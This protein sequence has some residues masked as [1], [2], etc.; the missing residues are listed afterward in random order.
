M[1]KINIG[2]GPRWA[3]PG[4]KTLDF[5]NQQA[6]LLCDLRTNPRLPLA[7]AST[8]K[9]YCSH[10][11][12]HLTDS[13]VLNLFRESR[14]ILKH[15][16]IARF[17]CPDLEK[18]IAQ[19]K[20]GRCDPNAEIIT[21]TLRSAPSHLRLLNVVASFKSPEYRG[22]V[23]TRSG[24]YSGGPFAEE[25]EV[26]KRLRSQDLQSFAD[27][28]QSLVPEDAFY[29]AHINAFWAEKLSSLLSEAGFTHIRISRYRCSS[30]AELRGSCFD[31][32][33]QL[34]L[35]AEVRATGK[36]K[37]MQTHLRTAKLK[38]SKLR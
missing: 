18:A 28:V 12:E 22:T 13:A 9:I 11:I 33:P 38:I 8:Q 14:R 4:W 23:N 21:R 1:G 19:H 3:K 10:V 25:A 26:H 31:N 35:F 29:R 20:A 32:R 6:D 16:G 30:D 5:Y 36:K 37:L 24:E 27:W 15:N 34:S 17:A 2:P 7:S